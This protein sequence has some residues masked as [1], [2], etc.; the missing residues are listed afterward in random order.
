MEEFDNTYNS[1]KENLARIYASIVEKGGTAPADK[2]FANLASTIR[3]IP[4]G[5]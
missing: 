4:K 3:S 1:I 5:N 2:N